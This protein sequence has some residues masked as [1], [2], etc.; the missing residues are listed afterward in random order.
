MSVEAVIRDR[1]TAAGLS[2]DEQTVSTRAGERI[3][4]AD[5]VTTRRN[6]RGLD[7]ANRERKPASRQ[8]R[9]LRDG[10]TGVAARCKRGARPCQVELDRPMSI[11]LGTAT[12]ASLDEF[13]EEVASWQQD[14]RPVQL[15]PGALARW[16]AMSAAS[17]YRRARCL[18][19]YDANDAAVA[20]ATVWS[21]G[22][23]RPGLLEPLG[24]HRDHRGHGHGTA[25]SLA[26][27]AAL[28]EMGASSAT[29]CTPSSN[30]GG[31]ATY[32]AAGF[33]ALRDVTDFRRTS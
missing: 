25:I 17:P 14:G 2:T 30:V 29:V 20:V 12:V 32:T 13:A 18:V 23:G 1:R 21:A 24:V 6:D 28:R 27:A 22:Q 10:G 3:G 33:T 5:R 9:M 26:A 16:H 7:V 4:V 31:V 19:G 8:V 15:H 11:T